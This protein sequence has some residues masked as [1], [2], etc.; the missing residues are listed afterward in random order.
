MCAYFQ[1]DFLLDYIVLTRISKWYSV[2]SFQVSDSGDKLYGFWGLILV[3]RLLC[4]FMLC[5][6]QNYA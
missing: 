3:D 2:V 6:K 5:G 1:W 4:F